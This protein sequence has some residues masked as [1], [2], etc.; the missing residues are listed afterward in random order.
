M[1][2]AKS[3]WKSTVRETSRNYYFFMVVTRKEAEGLTF[4][5]PTPP[6]KEIGGYVVKKIGSIYAP[7]GSFSNIPEVRDIIPDFKD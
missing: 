2:I 4:S 1:Q 7:E 3:S 5:S 6:S